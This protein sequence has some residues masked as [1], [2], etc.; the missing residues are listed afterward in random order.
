MLGKSRFL[1]MMLRYVSRTS[2]R[3][4]AVGVSDYQYSA[5]FFSFLANNEDDGPSEEAQKQ[6]RQWLASYNPNTIP[7]RLCETTS[8]RSSGPG[9][10]HVNKYTI[11]VLMHI[12]KLM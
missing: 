12:L 8:S 7:K 6:A 4:S 2:T 1:Q 3:F 11:Q 10:Q 5:R 9:G